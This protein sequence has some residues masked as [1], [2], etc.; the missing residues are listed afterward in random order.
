MATFQALKDPND[1]LDYAIDW[2]QWVPA[3][4]V[5]STSTWSA[6][7]A[8]TLS[9]MSI[10]TG[11]NTSTTYVWA[12]GGTVGEVYTVTNRITTNNGRVEDRSIDFTMVDR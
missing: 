8:L 3:G 1:F 10:G 5:I 6:P 7:A 9:S 4:D 12:S 2:S 11:T